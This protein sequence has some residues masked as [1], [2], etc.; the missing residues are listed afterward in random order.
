MCP[1]FPGRMLKSLLHPSPPRSLLPHI[2]LRSMMQTRHYLDSKSDVSV[3]PLSLSYIRVH[4]NVDLPLSWPE[5]SCMVVSNGSI[6]D[7]VKL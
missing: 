7:I 3:I 5:Y 1:I 6:I 4:F 2:L